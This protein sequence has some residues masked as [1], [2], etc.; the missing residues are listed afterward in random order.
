MVIKYTKCGLPYRTPPYSAAEQEERRKGLNDTPTI[1]GRYRKPQGQEQQ[2]HQAA[3]HPRERGL[4]PVADKPKQES[5]D[6]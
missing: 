4:V 2:P 5:N 6:G 3:Q 1:V